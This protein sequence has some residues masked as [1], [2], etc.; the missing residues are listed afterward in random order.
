MTF[1]SS[2]LQ[3]DGIHLDCLKPLL[4]AAP[5]IAN[6]TLRGIE[7]AG[8]L[9]V[10]LD[11]LTNL[12]VQYSVLNGDSLVNILSA[13]PNLESLKYDIG[14]IDDSGYNQFTI[15]EARAAILAHALNL[16]SL[17]LDR[18]YD[19]EDSWDDDDVASMRRVM[20]ERGIR[21]EVHLAS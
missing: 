1:Q 14:E 11:K 15:S 13:C 3:E 8:T 9:E 4:R 12:D 18:S 7:G 19:W 6:L 17:H 10:I 20:E 21:L 5:N 16:N 2:H